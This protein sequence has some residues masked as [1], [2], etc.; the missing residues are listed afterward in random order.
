MK[1]I[2]L[3]FL[4]K[5]I[6]M[7]SSIAFA[8]NKSTIEQEFLAL[9]TKWMNARKSKDEKTARAILA[10]DFTLTS[11][12]STGALITKEQW[13][14]ALPKYDCK[15]FHF[16]TIKVRLYGKTAIVNSWYHQEATANGKDWNGNFF[17]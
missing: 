4:T 7:F 5:L 6:I 3:T 14:A 15:S 10:D 13:I 8:Q 17:D 9:E 12:L 1:V 11:S 2:L 16:D